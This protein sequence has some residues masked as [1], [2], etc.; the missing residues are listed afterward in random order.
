[1]FSFSCVKSTIGKTCCALSHLTVHSGDGD[2]V[3]GSNVVLVTCVCFV[4][5]HTA[6]QWREL[7]R[8]AEVSV[9]GSDSRNCCT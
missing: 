3:V 6:K 9:R 8:D 4:S 7:L 2:V 5:R 1:M